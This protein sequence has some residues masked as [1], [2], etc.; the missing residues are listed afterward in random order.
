MSE[1]KSQVKDSLDMFLADIKDKDVEKS[2]SLKIEPRLNIDDV[3]I[4]NAKTVQVLST[5][6]S[7]EIPEEKSMSKD[8][9]SL[10]MLDVKYEK[11]KHQ[12]ICQ[13]A[14]FRYQYAVIMKQLEFGK[15]EF[16]KM[17]GAIIK[18]WLEWVELEK[19]GQQKLYKIAL[20]SKPPNK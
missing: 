3:G 5:P 14:S 9:N 2:A 4:E 20:I 10:L 1:K 8:D 17:I 11:V 12:F 18:I 16:G 19:W 6:Y 15:K 13:A 7:V